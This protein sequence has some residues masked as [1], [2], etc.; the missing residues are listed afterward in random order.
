[1][2]HGRYFAIVF[3]WNVCSQLQPM[4]LIVSLDCLYFKKKRSQKVDCASFCTECM[5][6]ALRKVSRESLTFLQNLR[7]R[8][9][10]V[11]FP[12]LLSLESDWWSF[13]LFIYTTQLMLLPS[14]LDF[15]LV[16]AFNCLLIR[17][18]IYCLL[19]ND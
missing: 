10:R 6:S 17:Q 9:T 19:S 7:E 1:M 4:T 18:S 15:R 14:W 8:F 13:F 16:I 12:K 5:K 11:I 2:S 3:F